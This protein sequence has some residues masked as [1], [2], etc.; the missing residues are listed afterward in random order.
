MASIPDGGR[1]RQKGAGLDL[2]P[3]LRQRKTGVRLATGDDSAAVD[4][5]CGRSY[6]F[7]I[8]HTYGPASL[9][10]NT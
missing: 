5:A 3:F 1:E 4:C 6:L 8:A 10:D 2:P 9:S 7:V